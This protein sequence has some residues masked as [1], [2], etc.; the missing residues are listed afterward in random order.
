MSL[1]RARSG[2]WEQKTTTSSF[3]RMAILIPETTVP[4]ESAFVTRLKLTNLLS[5]LS[6]PRPSAQP[7]LGTHHMPCRS[8][9]VVIPRC[10]CT[11]HRVIIQEERRS[12]CADPFGCT[13]THPNPKLS[14]V[15]IENREQDHLWVLY[16]SSGM[17][18]L[19]YLSMV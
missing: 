1:N 14:T 18:H 15:Y 8:T 19:M 7:S 2:L 3:C 6:L 12:I 13:S 11:K 17:S 4:R 16:D 10:M 5:D 9:N